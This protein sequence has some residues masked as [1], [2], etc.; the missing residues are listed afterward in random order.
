MH[1]LIASVQTEPSLTARTGG[2]VAAG[3]GDVSHDVVCAAA[4]RR[5]CGAAG[6]GT[7]GGWDGAERCSSM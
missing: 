1:A 3:H 4:G 6:V 5:R 2:S 7:S